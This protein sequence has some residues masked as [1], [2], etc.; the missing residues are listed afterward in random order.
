MT[1]SVSHKVVFGIDFG[2]KLSGNT[3]I[4]LFE[5]GKI[6]FMSVDQDVDADDFILKAAEHFKP[7]IIFLDAPLSLP[8]KYMGLDGFDNYHFRKAD[9]ELRAMS[10]MFLGGLTA[11]AMALKDT[12]RKTDIRVYETYPRI[13]ADQFGLRELGYKNGRSALTASRARTRSGPR[14]SSRR[15]ISMPGC[16]PCGCGIP[17]SP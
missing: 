2:S 12:L 5:R 16:G 14:P 1:S 17:T 4:A 8:G 6:Y 9:L 11:R 13:L 3:A 10:P 7:E 15:S